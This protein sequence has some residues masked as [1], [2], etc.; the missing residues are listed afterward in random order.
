MPPIPEFASTTSA[1]RALE[2]TAACVKQRP[3]V[4]EAVGR[5]ALIGLPCRSAHG[6][7]RAS[8]GVGEGRQAAS[9]MK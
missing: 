5:A 8:V 6:A 7:G 4:G 3:E 9:L 2:P 1:E